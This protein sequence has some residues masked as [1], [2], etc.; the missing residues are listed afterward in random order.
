MEGNASLP[1]TL[2]RCALWASRRA[3]E[4]M[5]RLGVTSVYL[6]TDL[7][8]D[9]SGTYWGPRRAA[10]LAALRRLERALPAARTPRL[11]AFIAAIPDAGVRA[12]V[13]AAIC[14]EA[15]A[16]LSTTDV[17]D[18]CAKA[19]HGLNKAPTPPPPLPQPYHSSY[20]EYILNPTPT[21][22]PNL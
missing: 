5:R 1:G 16:L 21:P 9:A 11:R 3:K 13:E 7:R 18:D 2:L 19:P 17:C 10:A 14:T 12:S 20:Y 4:T 6:A 15:Q 8:S 22:N